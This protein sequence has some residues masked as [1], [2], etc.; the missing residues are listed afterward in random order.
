MAHKPEFADPC[1]IIMNTVIMFKTIKND[2]L[3]ANLRSYRNLGKYN[4]C[5][6]NVK[7]QKSICT[8]AIITRVHA[9]GKR[10]KGNAGGKEWSSQGWV[11]PYNQGLLGKWVT[12]Q[13]FSMRPQVG[14]RAACEE[15]RTRDALLRP[16]LS[17]VAGSPTAP[18]EIASFLH[19][20]ACEFTERCLLTSRGTSIMGQT[21]H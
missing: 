11:C 16:A 2:Y 14:R 21:Q 17:A 4:R 10:L 6:V 9:H 19:S 18:C 1:S 3:A 13:P 12:R 5:T 7:K 15:D 20:I 8:I